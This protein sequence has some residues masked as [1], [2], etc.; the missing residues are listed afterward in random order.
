MSNPFLGEVRMF[1]GN[2]AIAGWAMCQG[3]LESIDQNTSLFSLLGTTYGGDG[4]TT[5]AL[6]DLRGRVPMHQGQGPGLSNRVIGESAGV[7]TVS[8]NGNQM[9]A[10]THSLVASGNPADHAAPSSSL[11]LSQMTGGPLY[12]GATANTTLGAAGLTPSGGGQPHNNMQPY[13]AVNFIIATTGI[14][15]SPN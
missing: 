3:Q 15:P 12:S 1:A 13:L 2:F 11:V 14:F 5:F 10:H 8:L 4:Q 6:P 9:P 7:E